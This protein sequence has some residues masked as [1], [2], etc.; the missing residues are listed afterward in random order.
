MEDEGLKF[1]E[2]GNWGIMKEKALAA[3]EDLKKE[4]KYKEKKKKT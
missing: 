2:I 1:E 4:W 3:L